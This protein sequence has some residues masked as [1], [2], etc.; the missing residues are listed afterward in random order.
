VQPPV[1]LKISPARARESVSQSIQQSIDRS[2][3]TPASIDASIYTHP[4]VTLL[5]HPLGAAAGAAS[6]EAGRKARALPAT[7]AKARA[8]ARTRM[9]LFS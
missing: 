3:S 4:N 9:I 6:G 8:V 5:T 1:V 7:A 2:T